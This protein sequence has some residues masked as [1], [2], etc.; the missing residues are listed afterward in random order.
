MDWPS[1]ASRKTLFVKQV[2]KLAPAW[3]QEGIP[4]AALGPGV[5]PWICSGVATVL[6]HRKSIGSP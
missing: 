2:N 5:A 6:F 4:C 3:A 1:P